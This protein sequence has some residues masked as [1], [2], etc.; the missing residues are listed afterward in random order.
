MIV[1]LAHAS[2]SV[3]AAFEAACPG[4]TVIPFT[5]PHPGPSS[6][7]DKLVAELRDRD[8]RVLPWLRSWVTSRTGVRLGDEPITLAWYSAGY[9]LARA[10]ANNAADRAEVLAW[11]GIDG[12]HTDFDRDGTASDQGVAWAARL[13]RLAADRGAPFWF[14][15][16]DVPTGGYASTT[17]FAAEIRRISGEPRGNWVCEAH[18]VARDHA[19]EHRAA[20]N[21]WGPGFLARC[22]STLPPAEARPTVRPPFGERALAVCIAELERD[23]RERPMGSN[24]GTD[25]RRYLTGCVRDV[26][27]DGDL[28][29]LGLTAAEWCAAAQGWA[30]VEARDL[31]DPPGPC[32]WRA[33]GIEI[34]T[35][36]KARGVWRSAEEVRAGRYVLQPG[37]LVLYRRGAEAWMRHVAR[38]EV[39]SDRLGAYRTIGGNEG[40]RWRRTT[41]S[42]FDRDFLGAVSYPRG[43]A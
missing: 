35:D 26:D 29:R 40:D 13:A 10:L 42:I 28:E 22:L 20:L 24:G 3:R 39:R 18:D 9:A 19:E 33:S 31:D 38:V 11:V 37:D 2:P 43:G 15:H 17:K 16:S 12:G 5:S 7:Y 1:L 23:A 36:A 6:A 30:D 41:R 21:V 4:A 14:G 34:E 8:G 25:V 32:Y 27:G